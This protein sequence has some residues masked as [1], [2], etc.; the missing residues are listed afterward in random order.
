MNAQLDANQKAITK[1]IRA[2]VPDATAIIFHGSRVRGLP[3][4]TSDYD[5][6]ILNPTGVELKDRKRIKERLAQY[7]P[8]LKLDLIFGSERYLLA[9]LAFEPYPRFWLENG[10]AL[11][12]KIPEAKPYPR[13]YRGSLDSRLHV[14]RAE[15]GVVDVCYRTLYAK[16]RGYLRILKNLVLIENALQG[17]YRNES[18]WMKVAQLVGNP[19]LQI[20]RDPSQRHRIRKPMVNRLRRIVMRKLSSLRKENLRSR[21]TTSRYPKSA[22]KDGKPQ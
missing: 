9:S 20:L 11:Y 22:I 21:W 16:G 17:D 2:L 5:I 8:D 4:A 14:I 6:L 13:I 12:G 10:V 18:L 3:S 1:K 7:F 19:T 15:V